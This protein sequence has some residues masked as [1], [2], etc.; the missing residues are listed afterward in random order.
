MMRRLFLFLLLASMSLSVLAQTSKSRQ[1]KKPT[2]REQLQQRQQQLHKDL[3]TGRKRQQ[4]LERQVKARMKDVEA[5]GSEIAD[6][7]AI[8]DSLHLAIDTLEC[9]ITEVNSQL[10]LL[11]KELQ[12]RQQH[13][14]RS[15]RYMYRNRHMQNQ[16]MFVLSAQNFNQMYRRMRFMNE[17]TVYQRAQG[18]AVK[19]KREQVEQKLAELKEVK[20][21]MNNLLARGEEE[22]KRLEA[23]KEDQQKLVASL[24]REEQTVKRLITQQQKEEAELNKQIDKLIAEEL[25]RARKAEEERQRQLA[26][27]R[28][29]EEEKRREQ[30]QMAA[31]NTR[32]STSKTTKNTSTAKKSDNTVSKA[33]SKNTAST[34]KASTPSSSSLSSSYRDADPDRQL[35]GSFASNK[36]RL[37]VPITGSY[38]VVRG[39]GAYSIAGVTLQSSGIHLE[40]QAGA[41]AR[42]VF[43]GEVS[44]VF[45]PGNGIVVMVRHGRYISVYSGLSS[46][47]VSMG[48]KVKTNQI[49]GNVGP[50]HTLLFRL[51]NWDQLLNPK[52]WLKRL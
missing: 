16:L 19:Q 36:G 5:L 23:K 10:K 27:Q 50:S 45:N 15:V 31:N 51:Q 2:Q 35:S 37:P 41:Q 48:Q 52:A 20:K 44:R 25:E 4:E 43:D 32:R 18:E 29:R 13:Y 39:F 47:T 22:Q 8:I 38:R 17:Y 33:N 6:K 30:Q 11:R 42:C 14:I 3:Q 12:E 9:N 1:Q 40:G 26:E 46:A 28:R 7:Q 49:L 34:K 21:R 24:Q